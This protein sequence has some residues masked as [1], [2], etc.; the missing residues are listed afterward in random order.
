MLKSLDEQLWSRTREDETTGCLNWT[1]PVTGS[2]Y[3]SVTRGGKTRG[4][5]VIAWEEA[6][7]PLP[8]GAFVCHRCDN[9][10]CCNHEHLFLGDHSANMQDMVLKGRNGGANGY[11]KADAVSRERLRQNMSA[12]LRGKP[13]N[14][15]MKSRLS[16]TATGRKR[17]YLADGSW[18]W[19][20]G[21]R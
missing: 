16:A 11:S 14:E 3:G 15:N 7:G 20:Y 21:D 10:R 18:T 8:S 12:K 2:G 19:A 4:A 9:P 6:N 5:H 1:G 13:K 17:A